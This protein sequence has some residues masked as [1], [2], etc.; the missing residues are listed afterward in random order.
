MPPFGVDVVIVEPGPFGTGLLASSQT[1][2]H[3][4]V[5]AS[6]GELA[7]VPDAVVTHFDAYMKSEACPKPQLVVDA[8]LALA[9]MLAGKRPTRTVVGITW[10]V[11]EMNA[12]KQPIQDRVLKEMQ[13]EGVL[14]GVS[15]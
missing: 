1:P 15:A 9:D 2:V 8:Y 3:G 4:D 5:L 11:D 6:Y 7:G 13:L 14:G 10:G 12:A